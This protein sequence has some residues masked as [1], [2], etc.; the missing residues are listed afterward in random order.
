MIEFLVAQSSLTAIRSGFVRDLMIFLS[1]MNSSGVMGSWSVDEWSGPMQRRHKVSS[2]QVPF[3]RR[4]GSTVEVQ[5]ERM[6]PE[7]NTR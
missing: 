2:F 4:S 6:M 5:A 3:H 1:F 7:A